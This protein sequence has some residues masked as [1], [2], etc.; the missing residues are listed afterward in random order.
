MV[1]AKG[2][3]AQLGGKGRLAGFQCGM[4]EGIA[5]GGK[6]HLAGP[7]YVDTSHMLHGYWKSVGYREQ[8]IL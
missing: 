7:R 1:D 8:H 6:H 3:V 4:Q 5:V 2:I